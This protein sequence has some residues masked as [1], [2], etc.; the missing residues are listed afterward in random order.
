[1][2]Y[3]PLELFNKLYWPY[4]HDLKN[5]VH[6][7]DS[8]TSFVSAQRRP[9]YTS[10]QPSTHHYETSAIIPELPWPENREDQDQTHRF[11]QPLHILQCFILHWVV[12]RRDAKCAIV[13]R[14]QTNGVE[15][16]E[17]GGI[18]DVPD[19][20]RCDFKVSLYLFQMD[21]LVDTEHDLRDAHVLRKLMPR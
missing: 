16:I 4:S 21:L 6:L 12:L 20:Y 10:V 19:N 3:N 17:F 18:R 11:T 2:N 1:M 5:V 15:A 9:S 14:G 13:V 8:K 7:L